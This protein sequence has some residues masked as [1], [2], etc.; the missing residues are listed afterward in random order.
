MPKLKSGLFQLIELPSVYTGIH[1]HNTTPTIISHSLS[2]KSKKGTCSSPFID[3]QKGKVV[4]AL[5]Y[6]RIMMTYK[7]GGY[8]YMQF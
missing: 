3:S 7:E 6:A 1:G 5:N 8:K 4:S 2:V